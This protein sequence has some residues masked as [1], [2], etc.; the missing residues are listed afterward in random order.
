MGLADLPG[1]VETAGANRQNHAAML[2]QLDPPESR[3][4]IEL[5]LFHR[6]MCDIAMKDIDIHLIV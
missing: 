6:K 2:S 5:D 3:S 1:Q 4:E